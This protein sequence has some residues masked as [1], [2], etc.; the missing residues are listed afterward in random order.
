MVLLIQLKNLYKHFNGNQVL[1]GLNLEI[2]DGEIFVIL[3][4]SG[5]GKSVLLKHITGLMK[6]DEGEVLV[7]HEDMTLLEGTKLY[8]KL[9]NMGMIFQMGALFDSL[10][11]GENVAFYL[12]EHLKRGGNKIDKSAIKSLVATSLEKVGLKGTEDL[13]PSSLSG[14]MKKRASIAR[15]VIYQPK[16]LLYDEPTTGL[17][18]VTAQTIAKLIVEQ[19]QELQGTTIV[20]SHDIVT[21]LYIADRIALIVDGMIEIAADPVTFMQHKHPTIDLFNQMIGGNLDLIRKRPC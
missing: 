4:Q 2:K 14:G 17:D 10:T 15:C 6:A 19:Q 16:Y 7:D 20:V 5:S 13:Y 1:K 21:T 8:N 11:V 12:T 9:Q 3:G 18:P